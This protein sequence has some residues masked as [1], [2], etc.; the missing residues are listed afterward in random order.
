MLLVVAI[1]GI[2]TAI[3]IPSY[4]NMK[5]T[6]R[7]SSGITLLHSSLLLARTEAITRGRSVTVCRTENSAA[8]TPS[9][10]NVDS[11]KGTNNGWG[12]GW[13]I[14][15]DVNNDG[16]YVTGDLDVLLKVQGPMSI[17]ASD[18][19]IIPVDKNGTPQRFISFG[20]YRA[21]FWYWHSNSD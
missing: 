2:V 13:L 7:I 15:V 19:G 8:A 21:S 10:S 18:L 3:A 5:S 20:A 1:A 17:D 14:F 16:K 9:C 12:S 6:S 4:Q 11:V